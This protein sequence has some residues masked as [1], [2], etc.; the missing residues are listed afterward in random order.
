MH[1]VDIHIPVK[2]TSCTYIKNKY[3]VYALFKKNELN[4]FY[5]GKGINN[6][7][8]QHFM[9]S[10]L[11]E[12]NSRKN[13]TIRK[14]MHDIRKEILCYFDLEQSAFDFEE[15]LIS[16]Y[17]LIDEGGCLYNIAK[18]RHEFPEVSK[19]A[20][21]DKKTERTVVYTEEDVVRLYKNYFENR[22]SLRECIA[23][24]SIPYRYSSA[25]CRGERFKGLYKKYIESGIIKNLRT[26]E[27]DLK[28]K[29]PENQK[30]SDQQLYDIFEKVCNLEMTL[31]EACKEVGTEP[32]WVSKVFKGEF[33][34]YLSF[35]YERY[36]NLPKGR[37][38]DQERSYWKFK[39]LYPEV[40]DVASLSQSIGKSKASIYSY[41]RRYNAEFPTEDK[42]PRSLRFYTFM[43]RN[44]EVY[45]RAY[46]LFFYYKMN[47]SKSKVE[48]DL[49]FVEGALDR[50]F[51]HFKDGWIPHEDS[52]WLKTYTVNEEFEIHETL[53]NK[54]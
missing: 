5:V 40:E 41:I 10:S 14:Y 9:N 22:M 4:P 32:N 3:Y 46:E 42:S 24:T 21:S 36:S 37:H 25:L 43:K 39:E 23:G 54:I 12:S 31:K 28:R 27:D 45:S 51:R 15:Y 50:I 17:G 6:R 11:N 44:P 18:S 20:I 30:I 7:I 19:K 1:E 13:K 34:K 8:D 29:H 2:A 35:D 33:R 38:I 52:I 47:N 26:P 16:Y 48:K 53:C 49:G